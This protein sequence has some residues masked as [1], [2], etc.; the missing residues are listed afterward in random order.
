MLSYVYLLINIIANVESAAKEKNDPSYSNNETSGTDCFIRKDP[1]RTEN[2]NKRRLSNPKLTN[3][4]TYITSDESENKSI[5]S[6]EHADKEKPD[7]DSSGLVGKEEHISGLKTFLTSLHDIVM[8]S[9]THNNPNLTFEIQKRQINTKIKLFH[10]I[11]QIKI[12]ILNI[13]SINFFDNKYANNEINRVKCLSNNLLN[14]LD[15]FFANNLIFDDT[16]NKSLILFFQEVLKETRSLC[17]A[18]NQNS[19]K[20]W[21]NGIVSA[22]ELLLD[23]KA[24]QSSNSIQMYDILLKFSNIIMNLYDFDFKD[25]TVAKDIIFDLC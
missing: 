25:N 1:K 3:E 16:I 12:I 20:T 23:A 18:S 4:Q 11:N 6:T 10:A 13:E 21:I 22:V 15:A 17:L 5:T 24:K 19:Y 2:F 9:E 8:A 7:K 14:L